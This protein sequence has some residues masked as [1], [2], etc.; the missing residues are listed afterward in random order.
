MRNSRQALWVLA[1]STHVLPISLPEKRQ[2][3]GKIPGTH[4]DPCDIAVFDPKYGYSFWD[5]RPGGLRLVRKTLLSCG[6]DLTRLQ[7]GY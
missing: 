4:D 6:M 7:Q 3:P 5:G 2:A 1:R